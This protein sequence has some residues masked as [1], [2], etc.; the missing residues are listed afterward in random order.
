MDTPLSRRLGIRVD[1]LRR[2]PRSG[3]RVARDLGCGVIELGATGGDVSPENLSST[4]RRDLARHVRSLGL[5]LGA[6]G[7]ESPRGGLIDPRHGERVLDQTLRI[8]ELARDVGAGVVTTAVHAPP[9]DDTGGLDRLREAL[10]TLADRA[11]RTGA[12]LSLTPRGATPL[13]LL[14]E[15]KRVGCPQL[16]ACL[17]AGD[18]LAA[19]ADPVEVAATWSD[20]LGWVLA[21]DATRGAPGHPGHEVTPG[22]GELDP[23]SLLAG[24]D[25]A[26]YGGPI[27][28][29]R[30]GGDDPL[31]EFRAAAQAWRSRLP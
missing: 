11:D 27:V 8:I 28:L 31:G 16:R 20:R 14:N 23:D 1:D 15:L 7:A 12:I 24:L 4:G 19:G 13:W 18:W 29:A 30:R 6:L 2:D 10:A 17:D 26:A 5:T 22:A 3:I 25:G 21:R 9:P